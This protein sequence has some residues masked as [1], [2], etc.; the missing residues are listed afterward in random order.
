MAAFA[1]YATIVADAL[2]VDIDI[3]FHTIMQE[4]KDAGKH[5]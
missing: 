5:P 3:G 1:V 4:A 2:Q